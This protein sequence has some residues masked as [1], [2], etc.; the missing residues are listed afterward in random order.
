MIKALLTV[1]S[2]ATIQASETPSLD[3]AKRVYIDIP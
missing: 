2:F 3:A 1:A